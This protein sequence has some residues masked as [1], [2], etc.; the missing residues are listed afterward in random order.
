MSPRAILSRLGQRPDIGAI[1][2]TIAVVVVFSV[3]D[4]D[5]FWSFF[6]LLNITQ[7]TAI[8]G[9]LAVGEM[10]VI[11][12]GEIDLSVGS[13]YGLTAIA[14]ILF[15]NAWGVPLGFLAAM[16]IAV[17]AGLL[18]ALL[19]LRAGMVSMIATL[20]ALFF[21]RGI[22]YVWTGGT[23]DALSHANRTEWLTELFGANWL[24]LENGFFIFLL[25]VAFVQLLLS[26]T[27]SGNHLLAVGGDAASA[28]SRGVDVART[29]TLAFIS[30]SALA[31]LSGI[32]TVS[33][34]PQT[35]VT[36]GEQ[37]ELSAIAA[38]V[39]GGGLLMGGRG[40][41]IGAAL[42]AFIITA[43]QYELIGLGAPSSWFITFVG[44][45]LILAVI[46][47]HWIGSTLKLL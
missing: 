8:V 9:L 30:S 13:V 18:N 38:A 14:F 15:S 23:A 36:L 34:Q 4:F 45:V 12:T 37:M 43:V 3:I 46:V 2:G 26:G 41:A 1:A 35:H 33:D 40:S 25:V 27:R 20:A 17:L 42:G 7:Y 32:V 16:A 6:T 31:G 19:V 28:V 24:W 22:I 10:M 21:Y 47:N 11:L 29:K 5:G 44:I 39:V